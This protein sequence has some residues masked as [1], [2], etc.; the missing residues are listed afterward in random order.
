MKDAKG[1]RLRCV[2]RYPKEYEEVSNAAF[3]KEQFHN[4][5]NRRATIDRRINRMTPGA[6]EGAAA[7]AET[8]R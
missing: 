5:P 3:I 8:Q 7:K 4:E 6:A 2:T 1:A